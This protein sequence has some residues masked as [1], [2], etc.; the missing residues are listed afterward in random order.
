M[1]VKVTE[2]KLLNISLCRVSPGPKPEA[3]L[4]CDELMSRCESYSTCCQ[5]WFSV[6]CAKP[7]TREPTSD[8]TPNT[9]SHKERCSNQTILHTL[10]AGKNATACPLVH[11]CWTSYLPFYFILDN[12]SSCQVGRKL[13]KVTELLTELRSFQ[14]C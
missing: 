14:L 1:K 12:R 10:N 7:R 3:Q 9:H 11:F 4:V 8:P 13:V 2:R 6:S 5:W